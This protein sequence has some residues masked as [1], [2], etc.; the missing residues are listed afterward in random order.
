MMENI[1]VKKDI[2]KVFSVNLIK[3]FA[4]LITTFFIPSILSIENYGQ[5]KLYLFYISYIGASHLGFCDGIYLKYGGMKKEEINSQ[6]ISAEH[7][8]ILVFEMIISLIVF[9]VGVVKYDFCLLILALTNVPLILIGFYNYIFQAIGD[10]QKYTRNQLI[11]TII[12]LLFNLGLICF[13]VDDYKIYILCHCI[14]QYISCVIAFVYFK[15]DK[16]LIKAK[17]SFRVLISN[18]HLG[19]LLLL[20]NFVYNLFVGLDKWFIKFSLEITDFS[21]Y[22]FASQLLSVIN[23]F[24]T[25]I[26]L[27]LYSNISRRKDVIF[28]KRVEKL[29]IVL[30][31]LTP[32][33][34]YIIE[35]IILLFLKKYSVAMGVIAILFVSHIFMSINSVFF[36]NVYKSYKMQKQY[37]MRMVLTLVI[38]FFMNVFV[39]EISPTIEHFALATLFSGIVWFVLNCNFFKYLKPDLGLIAFMIILIFIFGVGFSIDSVVIRILVYLLV[40]ILLIKVLLKDVWEYGCDQIT[41]RII[42]KN[43]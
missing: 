23:M 35:I 3:M 8:T 26:G 14:I 32:V 12:N 43:L 10:F 27:T 13:R 17:A 4:T 19:F 20:G 33:F 22:A 5:Y 29:L 30:L 16:W 9:V 25:P 40:Y 34:V 24:V 37:F 41:S 18:I 7:K 39:L 42:R 21:M 1:F 28:E 2:I 31:L 36:V 6:S 11:A 38:A 15:K